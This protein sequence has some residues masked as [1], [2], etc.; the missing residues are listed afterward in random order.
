MNSCKSVDLCSAESES[1]ILQP[2]YDSE[3][4]NEISSFARAQISRR[5][6]L[7]S[8]NDGI[9][10]NNEEDSPV[11]PGCC[12][13]SSRAIEDG[14]QNTVSSP[15]GNAQI[16]TVPLVQEVNVRDRI[17]EVPEVHITQKIRQKVI[18]KD[19]IR[20]VPKQEI[21]YVDKFVEVPE[22][23]IVDKFVSKPV[24]KY[25][26]R[27]VP[28]VEVREIVKEIPKIEIQYVEKIVEVPEVRVVDKIVEIPTIKHVIKEVPKIEVKEVQVE[29]IV[30]VPKIEIKQIEKERKVLGHV[31]YIDIPIEKIILKPNPQ[32]IEKIVQV[33]VPKEVE[34][35]VPVYNPDIK[36]T[37]EIEVDNYYTIEKEVEVPIPGKIIPVP[38]EVEVEKIVE[39]PVQ[40]PQEHIRIVQKQVPQYIEH[41]RTVEIPQYQDEFV[42]V[43]QYVPMVH[44]T[45]IKPVVSQEYKELPPV[46]EQGDA[47]YIKEP[48]QYLETEYIHGEPIELDC[49]TPLPAPPSPRYTTIKVNGEFNKPN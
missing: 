10:E 14:S 19:V 45:I 43:P 46:V 12:G 39:V 23:R 6:N 7:C 16:V 1:P 33:P 41:I 2:G 25:V 30:K 18:V 44:H 48:P 17:I 27:H 26:E 24:T 49:N 20:K 28:K 9:L 21:Q 4:I 47:R 35:E 34:I 8:A 3:E 29:K 13:S 37:I 42:E 40:V 36:N 11:A 5:G 22:V 15:G 38:V 32:I 31:E